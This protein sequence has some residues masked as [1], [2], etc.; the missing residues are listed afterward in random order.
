M[1]GNKG[2]SGRCHSAETRE[3][4][5]LTRLGKHLSP[6]TK[7]KM[8]ASTKGISRPHPPRKGLS[9][10]DTKLR[11][12]FP[13]GKGPGIPW[14]EVDDTIL[15]EK[16]QG[17]C[18]ICGE[19]EIVMLN[20]KTKKLSRDHNHYT[21]KVRGFLCNTCNNLLGF[22]KDNIDVLKKAVQYLEETK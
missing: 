1:K 7:A 6:E 12:E 3:K 11:R 13:N 19:R 8:S 4:I 18:R 20:D 22:A 16:Q 17:V 9:H 2:Y 5:R 14:T 21:G 15:Y 10:L